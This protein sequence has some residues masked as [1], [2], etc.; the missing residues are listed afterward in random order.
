MMARLFV[1]FGQAESCSDKVVLSIRM[2][3]ISMPLTSTLC[4]SGRT[5]FIFVV[6]DPLLALALMPHALALMPHGLSVM[7]HGLLLKPCAPLEALCGTRRVFY[8]SRLHVFI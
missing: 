8:D 2:V 5:V 3:Y 4:K 6:Y 7:R 1:A